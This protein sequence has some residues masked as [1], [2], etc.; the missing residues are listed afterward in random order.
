MSVVL[1]L[2][3]PT[4]SNDVVV[5]ACITAHMSTAGGI[6]GLKMLL[7]EYVIWQL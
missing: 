2:Y 5:L 1:K 4:G 6:T 3:V 7:Q